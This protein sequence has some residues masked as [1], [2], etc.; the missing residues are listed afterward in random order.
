MAGLT[1][2][3]DEAD[4]ALAA[5]ANEFLELAAERARLLREKLA[6]FD[7]LLRE[8][9]RI[10]DELDK[11]ED[12]LASQ[13]GRKTQE[14][15]FGSGTAKSWPRPSNIVPGEFTSMSVADAVREVLRREGREMFTGELVARLRAGGR[16]LNKKTPS[17]HV[18][19]SI[20]RMEGVFYMRKH[21]NK[22]KWGLVEWR[23]A[24]AEKTGD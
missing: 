1:P 5:T 17:S 23:G 20:R 22:A 2:K 7:D 19:T 14:A 9:Q 15:L 11:L 24:G 8:R 10:R 6:A 3:I 12:I 16:T 4:R 21:K 18:N 13:G